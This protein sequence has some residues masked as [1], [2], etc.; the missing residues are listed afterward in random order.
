MR[1][2]ERKM[3]KK[4]QDRIRGGELNS[5]KPGSNDSRKKDYED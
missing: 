5:L 4:N 1:A 2:W 3:K